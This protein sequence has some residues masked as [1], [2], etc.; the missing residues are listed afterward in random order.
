M[1]RY[2]LEIPKARRYPGGCSSTEAVTVEVSQLSE[3]CT[4]QHCSE[5]ALALINHSYSMI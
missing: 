1:V 5:N 4:S 3:H 2:Q